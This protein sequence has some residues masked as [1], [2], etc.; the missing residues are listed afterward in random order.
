MDAD[1][2]AAWRVA[3]LGEVDRRCDGDERS[4]GESQGLGRW[5]ADVMATKE[6]AEAAFEPQ[7]SRQD[8]VETHRRQERYKAA[9][10]RGFWL[11]RQHDFP[12]KK[13]TPAFRLELDT[14][15][16]LFAMSL[17]PLLLS[18]CD[19][20]QGK[21]LCDLASGFFEMRGS[22]RDYSGNG[23][24]TA[25]PWLPARHYKVNTAIALDLNEVGSSKMSRTLPLAAA[26][27]SVC[28]DY[29][30]AGPRH[31]EPPELPLVG[32]TSAAVRCSKISLKLSISF[33][34]PQFLDN[35][36]TFRTKRYSLRL[37][38]LISLLYWLRRV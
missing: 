21:E 27:L 5:I 29:R 34:S 26:L 17:P 30:V 11:L 18:S 19:G 36:H 3:R 12:V 25:Q 2:R 24:T 10:V 15:T 6:A 37:L 8:D 4:R 14:S 35:C 22:H 20:R 31:W 7:W 28:L 16:S 38:L 9:G 23:R 33:M 1:D 32:R 13:D